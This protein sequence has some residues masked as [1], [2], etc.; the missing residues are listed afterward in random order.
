MTL[1]GI[2]RS[3]MAPGFTGP[4]VPLQSADM[5]SRQW[6]CGTSDANVFACGRALGPESNG[7]PSPG[8]LSV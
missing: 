1:C 8:R 5:D 3:R 4:I 2:R 7:L 6:S